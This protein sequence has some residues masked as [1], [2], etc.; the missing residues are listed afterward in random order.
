MSVSVS[1]DVYQHKEKSQ[2]KVSIGMPVYNAEKYL[3]QTLDSLLNQ[4]FTDFEI[5]ISNNGSTDQT[6]SICD[7]YSLKDSRIKVDHNTVNQGASW[8]FN[9]VVEMA[10]GQ[11]FMWAAHDDLW[12]PQYVEKCVAVLDSN[13]QAVLCY[14]ATE[15]IDALGKTYKKNFG[16]K[17]ELASPEVSCRFSA[18]WRYPPQILV[19][20]LIR[21]EIL[22]KTR[23]IGDYAASDQVL[24]TELALAGQIVG[25][26]E[27][28]FF[29]RRHSLQST[30]KNYPT[31]RSRNSWYNPKNKQLLT[32]PWWRVLKEHV[33]AIT[34]APLALN[35]RLICY[36][37]VLRWMI[38]KR[39]ELLY[40]LALRDY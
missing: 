37:C 24:V 33:V 31:M 4:S 10:S 25:I 32:F 6:R 36:G 35:N 28:L 15:E 22:K 16:I 1:S 20:G 13:Q 38:R 26:P 27:P 3:R 19:F 21:R 14:T 2:P 17:P 30:A 18:S 5:V 29:Y 7:E 11:Y 34:R 23:L 8:N 40:E 9:H 12:H 39:R